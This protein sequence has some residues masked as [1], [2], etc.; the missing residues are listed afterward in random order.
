MAR[1]RN[2]DDDD[3]DSDRNSSGE[4]ESEEEELYTSVKDDSREVHKPVDPTLLWREISQDKDLEEILTKLDK[5][6]RS[7]KR[8]KTLTQQE[9]QQK[10]DLE[11]SRRSKE[12]L[13]RPKIKECLERPRTSDLERPFIHVVIAHAA[14]TTLLMTNFISRLILEE[15]P[16]QIWSSEKDVLLLHRAIEIETNNLPSCKGLTSGICKLA[17]ERS[18]QKAIAM[19]NAMKENCLHLIVRHHIHDAKGIIALAGSDA[20]K[21]KRDSGQ[22]DPLE[23]QN[24]PLH[25]ALHFS[26][27]AKLKVPCEEDQ[28]TQQGA[29]L[30]DECVRAVK[31]NKELPDPKNF[32]DR[33]IKPLLKG[34]SQVLKEHNA[35]GLPPYAFH[36]ETRTRLTQERS[37]L[38][39]NG[40]AAE[41]INGIRHKGSDDQPTSRRDKLKPSIEVIPGLRKRA[42]NL[43]PDNPKPVADDRTSDPVNSKSQDSRDKSREGSK[44][45][46]FSHSGQ[47][48]RTHKPSNEYD[49]KAS[50]EIVDSLEGWIDKMA[51]GYEDI[52]LCFFQNT[53]AKHRRAGSKPKNHAFELPTRVSMKT[54]DN[55]NFL[56]F[57]SRL[58]LLHLSLR[59]DNAYDASQSE[60]KRE[61]QAANDA[62]N[63][64][65]VFQ[66]LK[67]KGVKKILKVVVEDNPNRFCSEETIET[68]LKSMEEIR[69][70]NWNKRD[71]AVPTLSHAKNLTEL[72]LY[73]SG[74]NAV[75]HHWS[76]QTGLITL[77][78]L[79]K[80][81]LHVEKGLEGPARNQKNVR[82]FMTRLKD[83]CVASSKKREIEVFPDMVGMGEAGNASSGKYQSKGLPSRPQ[84]HPGFQ[85]AAKFAAELHKNL[86]KT[87][88]IGKKVKVALLDDGVNPEYE[89][90]G[91]H[92]ACDGFPQASLDGHIA[93]FYKS[94]N[95]HGSKMASIISTICP[96][97]EIYVAKIDN[98]EH[99]QH[100]A[101]NVEQAAAAVDWA[102]SENVDIISM[103]WILRV[104]NEVRRDAENLNDMLDNDKSKNIILYCAARDNRGNDLADAVYYPADCR[105][106]KS[107]GGADT[108]NQPLRYVTL[109]KTDFVFPSKSVL[110]EQDVADGGNSVATAVATGVA[111]LV[112]YCLREDKVRFK[113]K[114]T[115]VKLMELLFKKLRDKNSRYVDLAELFTC[116]DDEVITTKLL[117]DRVLVKAGLV[118]TELDGSTGEDFF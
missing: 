108:F 98:Q 118:R 89:S 92:L 68:C 77:P 85:A 26:K 78:K 1:G 65:K 43:N 20:F 53:K 36:L 71:L 73:S 72:T 32:Y 99:L 17:D 38:A 91:V 29:Q 75:L 74:I 51:W 61:E 21:Q 46:M 64:I 3:N 106:T 59:S 58:A 10:D 114:V 87:N 94:T 95:G 79:R 67:G 7:E 33:I 45:Q 56:E 100:P 70:L 107:I 110:P 96:F 41:P 63:I 101:Y 5:I 23:S 81:H 112:L 83:N 35:L 13:Y 102:V 115:P 27:V 82:D 11:A 16:D 57:E 30:C 117:A 104:T 8:N 116:R 52:I 44:P 93:P 28:P 2:G 50:K 86:S 34:C 69:F 22:K 18:R 113:A 62:D 84:K 19:T 24:T 66:W 15:D 54:T 48:P 4:S 6:R 60:E 40:A 47:G 109:D 25:D 88:S 105:T 97:V 9:Q 76:D 90:V 14:V 111:A 55:F 80:V 12:D 39:S 42:T 49:L 37:K 103:S 31:A